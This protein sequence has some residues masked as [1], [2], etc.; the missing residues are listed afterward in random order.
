MDC[1][2]LGQASCC[3]S[4]CNWRD[5][6]CK[7]GVLCFF[8]AWSNKFF[9]ILPEVMSSVAWRL[10]FR[11]YAEGGAVYMGSVVTD[12]FKFV[13]LVLFLGVDGGFG[14]SNLR[15]GGPVSHGEALSSLTDIGRVPISAGL[16]AVGM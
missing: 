4:F 5:A 8:W 6:S 15:N 14:S 11:K 10:S 9:H 12:D 1:S 7:L 3:I 13:L 16:W 2:P